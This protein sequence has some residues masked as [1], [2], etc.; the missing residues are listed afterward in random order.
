MLL[1]ENSMFIL[2]SKFKVKLSLATCINVLFIY[3]IIYNHFTSTGFDTGFFA[4]KGTESM[5]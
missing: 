5:M 4:R 1:M 3:Y 2:L